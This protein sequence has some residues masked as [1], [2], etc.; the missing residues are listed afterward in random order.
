MLGPTA[1]APKGSAALIAGLT[2][3]LLA[4][5]A[6]ALPPSPIEGKPGAAER[7]YLV[8]HGSLSDSLAELKAAE[9]FRY[10]AVDLTGA[11]FT[12]DALWRR[13]YDMATRRRFPV[14]AW[15]DVSAGLDQ[16]RTALQSL[17]V[18]GILVYGKDAAEAAAALRAERPALRIV[19][20]LHGGDAPPAEG[21]YG[22]VVEKGGFAA[23]RPEREIPVLVADRLAAREVKD[24]LAAAKGPC[25]VSEIPL[26]APR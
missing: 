4:A 7:G 10:L 17:S 12:E 13:H 19:P 3:V 25:L 5:M 26:F 24:L 8:R 2:V 22:L 1:E 18:A 23:S 21:E 15:V 11:R 20:V 6:A 14:W 16:A 9:G